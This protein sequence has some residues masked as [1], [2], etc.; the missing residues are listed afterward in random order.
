M[1]FILSKILSFAL[2]PTFWILI[3]LL[4]SIINYKRRKFYLIISLF[5]FLFF[6][7]DFIYK[8]LIKIWEEPQIDISKIQKEYELGI[9]LGGFS[10][11]DYKT[12][13][14]NF[15]KEADRLIYTVHLYNKKII[16]K[17]SNFRRKWK[18]IKQYL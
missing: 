1:F 14:H 2:K 18:S 8:K 16:K 5:T 13:R 6:G 10:E 17:N 11:Y 4:T 9:L 12:N 15:K 7:N 3:F